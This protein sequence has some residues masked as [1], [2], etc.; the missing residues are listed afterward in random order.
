MHSSFKSIEQRRPS[1]KNH[2][3]RYHIYIS[4]VYLV[5]VHKQYRQPFAPKQTAHISYTQTH[6]ATHHN[7]CT[8]ERKQ[9]YSDPIQ[10]YLSYKSLSAVQKSISHYK[11]A[12]MST[13]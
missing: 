2:S 11:T 5:T 10:A 9:N 12:R 13:R 1:L 4:Y 6:S 7:R 3:S 8:Q